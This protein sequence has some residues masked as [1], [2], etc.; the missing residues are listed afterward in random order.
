ME[1][2]AAVF[3]DQ[4]LFRFAPPDAE[5]VDTDGRFYKRADGCLYRLLREKRVSTDT[6]KGKISAERY[7]MGGNKYFTIEDV[8]AGKRPRVGQNGFDS[9]GMPCEYVGS[10]RDESI[11]YVRY[12]ANLI[13][14]ISP[15]DFRPSKLP[16]PLNIQNEYDKIKVIVDRAINDKVFGINQMYI[17]VDSFNGLCDS[18]ELIMMK[19][20]YLSSLMDKLGY[21]PIRTVKNLVRVTSD[22]EGKPRTIYKTVLYVNKS[23]QYKNSEILAMVQFEHLM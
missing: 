1:N 18:N 20:V 11:L 9:E 7:V 22:W 16:T 14:G 4:S 17:R 23:C 19:G 3:G 12:T 5:M 21:I 15:K 2:Y 10:N 6:T 13:K 8:I